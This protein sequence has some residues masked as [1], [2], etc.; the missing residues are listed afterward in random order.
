[1]TGRAGAKFALQSFEIIE[2][3]TIID[4][5]KAGWS[6]S[7]VAAIDFTASNGDPRTEYSNHCIVSEQLNDYEKALQDIG[8]AVE[9]EQ[10]EN[11]NEQQ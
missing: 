9:I 7:L 11:S 3:A 2:R 6:V 10:Y 8:G 5:L 1:M 4:Y